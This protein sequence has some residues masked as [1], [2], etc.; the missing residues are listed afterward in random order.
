V[1]A[2]ASR[3]L[4][5][6]GAPRLSRDEKVLKGDAKGVRVAVSAI[7]I[8]VLVSSEPAWRLYR[9]VLRGWPAESDRRVGEQP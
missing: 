5:H 9:K 1:K 2:L 6:S 8:R 4:L 7:E 3:P